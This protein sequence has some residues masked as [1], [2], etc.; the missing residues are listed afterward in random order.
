MEPSRSLSH[1]RNKSVI[2]VELPGGSPSVTKKKIQHQSMKGVLVYF[3]FHFFFFA[4]LFDFW[5]MFCLFFCSSQMVL[6]DRQLT[7]PA[8]PA[9]AIHVSIP[10]AR[11]IDHAR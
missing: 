3:S 7:P 11:Y 10:V 2:I 1:K 5:V 8:V 9:R 4:V 6:A